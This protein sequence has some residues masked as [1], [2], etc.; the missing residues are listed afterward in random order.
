MNISRRNFVGGVLAAGAMSGLSGCA[1]KAA[2]S[3]NSTQKV[4]LACVGI[5]CQAWNDIVEFMKTGECVIAALCDT[6]LGGKQTLNALKT[7]AGV[8]KFRDFRKMYDAMDGKI[9]AVLVGTPD[10]SH[11]CA[12]MEA[13]RRGI[14]VYVEKP[15]AHTFY[16]C[17]L[18][19]QAEKKYKGICQ[20][21]NQGHSGANPYQMGEYVEKGIIDVS[22]LT[23]V[24][25]HMNNPRRWHKWNGNVKS[26]PVGEKIPETLDWD[27][28]LSQALPHAYSKDFVQGEW[29]CWYDFGMGC[30]GDWGAHTMDTMHRFFDL[31]LPSEV[32]IDNVKG[33][34]PYVYPMQDTLTFTFDAKGKRPKIDL[35]WYE[36]ISNIPRLPEGYKYLAWG[37]DIP[38][39]TGSTAKA[40]QKLIPG[41]FFELSDG[42]AW[43]GGS[44][45]AT[46]LKIGV[47]KEDLPAYTQPKSNHWKNFLM[48]VKGEETV[49]SPFSRTAP[50]SQVFCLGVIAQRL[51]RNIK[52]DPS[53][54]RVV[55]DD[56]AD[57]LLRGPAPRK[58]WESYY[59]I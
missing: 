26:F 11:F 55:G 4:R 31:G 6:D 22:K 24:V 54:K 52:F 59:T 7:Y 17:E 18:L 38:P 16:E 28:W 8:P 57:A 44:H 10:F 2:A 53:T 42:S 48:A 29:R 3:L 14:P 1:T 27:L 43:E 37:G 58:G 34:N 21:G 25:A 35:E 50:L 12:T 47:A 41:R 46:L 20:M 32:K 33:W 49:N 40:A 13:I 39:A 9:D 56:I 19:M 30:L 23:R 15:L 36:G 5:G 45:S 51:N